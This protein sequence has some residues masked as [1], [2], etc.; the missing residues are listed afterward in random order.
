MQLYQLVIYLHKL[1]KIVFIRYSG[2]Y[3]CKLKDKII[4]NNIFFLIVG[5]RRC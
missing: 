4:N 1:K 5:K 3:N 2:V